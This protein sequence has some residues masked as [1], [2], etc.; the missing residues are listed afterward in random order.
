[1][2]AA[3]GDGRSVRRPGEVVAMVDASSV[4]SRAAAR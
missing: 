4:R 3:F 1:V 2:R